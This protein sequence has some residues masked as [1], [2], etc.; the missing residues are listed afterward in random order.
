MERRRS[1]E[2]AARCGAR[3][4]PVWLG[5]AAAALALA[6]AGADPPTAADYGRRVVPGG[7]IVSLLQDSDTSNL[8]IDDAFSV[9]PS[10]TTLSV[11][12]LQSLTLFRDNTDL[13]I[14]GTGD[15]IFANDSPAAWP[16]GIDL[17]GN[18]GQITLAHVGAVTNSGSGKGGVRVNASTS[19]SVTALNQ[20]SP[21]STLYLISY[22][23]VPG[24][25][26]AFQA[27]PTFA[28][29]VNLNAG[30]LFLGAN[31]S[32]V[33]SALVAGPTRALQNSGP[34]T[35]AGGT[36]MFATPSST[37]LSAKFTS[38]GTAPYALD[39]AGGQA[40]A[41]AS[42]LVGNGS[43]G[44]RKLGPGTLTLTGASDYT[45][46]TTIGGG[47]GTLQKIDGGTLELG[48]GTSGSL[49]G[50][51]GTDLVFAGTGTFRAAQA[52]DTAQG[53]LGLSF[54]R[55]DATIEAVNP[56]SGTTVLSFASAGPRPAGATV[57]YATS[58]GT[59]GTDVKVVLGGQA[60]GFLGSGTFFGGSA[61]AAS[62][63]GGHVRALAYGSDASAPAPV[64]AGPT[65]GATT[66]ADNLDL[67]GSITAQ[68][69]A[70]V[71]TLRIPNAS[72]LTLASGT[73]SLNGL[74]KSGGSAATI[75]GGSLA[76]A[77]AGGEVV[78]RTAA[79]A[80]TLTIL[81]P[82]AANGTNA[83]TKSGAGTLRLA[84][85]SGLTGDLAVNQGALVLD[86]PAARSL[87]AVAG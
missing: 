18:K 4:W 24:A 50:S 26:N 33:D 72:S 55:G 17:N 82:L 2:P 81:A 61:Y 79:A 46:P 76:P 27:T 60:A 87:P 78:V 69:T 25:G 37:D 48:D 63:A 59:N 12:G 68:R 56:G 22:I 52:P 66:A 5:A 53:M 34:I 36:L 86:M 65:L 35:F 67:A 30:I 70:A 42:P 71:N 47:T 43:K 57:N 74:L 44:L 19:A 21:S 40:V 7:P 31:Y 15:L 80:D 13:S 8:R 11:T 29:P 1:D 85:G 39:V 75:R 28:G 84:G 3:P 73:L 49:N 54:V 62:A 77:T 58:G 9:V 32:V 45:G 38:T 10:G 83:L 6:R 16:L 64:P 23:S 14:T 51:T 20:D 41:L